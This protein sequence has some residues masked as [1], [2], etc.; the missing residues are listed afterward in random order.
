MPTATTSNKTSSEA[1]RMEPL[2]GTSSSGQN[3]NAN[4][5]VGISGKR[6]R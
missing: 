3:G 2:G 5:E 1:I 6:A 4:T